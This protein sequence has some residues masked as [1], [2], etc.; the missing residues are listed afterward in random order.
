MVFKNITIDYQVVRKQKVKICAF[1][2]FL[3]GI[4]NKLG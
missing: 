2:L 4:F 3:G 1:F